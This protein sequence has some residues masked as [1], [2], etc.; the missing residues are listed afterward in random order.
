MPYSVFANEV[1]EMLCWL[2][3]G[4]VPTQNFNPPSDFTVISMEVPVSLKVVAKKLT[5]LLFTGIFLKLSTHLQGSITLSKRPDI[6]YSGNLIAMYSH[7]LLSLT[8]TVFIATSLTLGTRVRMVVM[9]HRRIS[10]TSQVKAY[11]WLIS[12]F[13][14]DSFFVD[15]R[16]RYSVCTGTWF[17]YRTI[18]K[19]K[20]LFC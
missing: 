10:L 6:S 1:A 12:L 5:Y 9:A 20:S 14:G 13:K 3:T 15:Y 17:R 19:S 4:I 8:G 18:L 11:Y 16:Y 2:S 7:F